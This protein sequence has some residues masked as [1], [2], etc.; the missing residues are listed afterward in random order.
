MRKAAGAHTGTERRED[1]AQRL[2]LTLTLV[3]TLVAAGGF[4]AGIKSPA[5]INR[6]SVKVPADAER[7]FLLRHIPFQATWRTKFA[8]DSRNRQ[9][10]GRAEGI[11][12]PEGRYLGP[13]HGLSC[14]LSTSVR[15]EYVGIGVSPNVLSRYDALL[16]DNAYMHLCVDV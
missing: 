14:P 1:T 3:L 10:L 8:P 6:T 11:W 16:T 5:G 9:G 7:A 15:S 13:R 4:L 12:S 2:V